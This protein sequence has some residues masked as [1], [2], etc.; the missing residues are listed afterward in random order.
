MSCRVRV[1][2]AGPPRPARTAGPA[3]AQDVALVTEDAGG[4]AGFVTREAA[5]RASA[6]AV[7]AQ[8]AAGA[9]TRA[10]AS[11]ALGPSVRRL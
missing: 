10:A 4:I 5:L 6:A 1:Q 7:A 11:P 3:G 8:A 2:A 9:G